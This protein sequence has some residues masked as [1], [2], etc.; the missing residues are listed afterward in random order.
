M[1]RRVKERLIGAIILVALVV[2][3]VPEILSGPHH[4]ATPPAPDPEPRLRTYTVDVAHIATAPPAP[5]P[6]RA[7][8]S[9]P[10]PAPV[11]ITPSAPIA[12]PAPAPASPL[13][14]SPAATTGWIVQLGSFARKAN[15]ESFVRQLK[16]EGFGAYIA[17]IGAGAAQRY[18]VRLGPIGDRST[19]AGIMTKLQA[20]RHASTLLPPSE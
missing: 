16:S 12:A 14:R 1:E 7:A 5:Q 4:G 15:A 17:P 2:L 6:P 18:R 10:E 9:A 11:P 13:V 19:A 8:S 20:H 3:L